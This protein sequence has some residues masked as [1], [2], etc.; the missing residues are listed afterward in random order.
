MHVAQVEYSETVK[1]RWQLL[2]HNVVA[3][4][5]NAFCIPAR[6][7]KKTRQLQGVSNDR[8]D[9]IPI[10]YVKG[11]EALAEDFRLVVRLDAQ[12]LS[13]VERSE[14]FLQF[15]KDIFVHGITSPKSARP[16]MQASGSARHLRVSADCLGTRSPRFFRPLPPM[17][18]LRGA[19]RLAPIAG[20]G[21]SIMGQSF[22]R[23]YSPD[24][25]C[26]AAI[27]LIL[28]I[29]CAQRHSDQRWRQPSS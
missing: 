23:R 2:E 21:P 26:R 7:P 17:P 15:T 11:E 24:G 25:T 14:T 22:W 29:A 3:L 12:S 19:R 13:R 28:T 8:M 9:R 6:T 20:S 10:P 16:S 27:H 18:G 5:E 1:K 4:D